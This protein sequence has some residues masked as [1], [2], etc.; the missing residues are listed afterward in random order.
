MS[1]TS[2]Y[3]E[4]I[5]STPLPATTSPFDPGYD[6][7]TLASHLQQSHALISILKLSMACWLIADETATRA[8]IESA[9]ANGVR[10]TTGGGPFEIAVA[11]GKLPEYLDVCAALGVDRVE[12]GEGFTELALTPREVIAMASEHGLEVQF[13]LGKK[14]E[15]AFAEGVVKGLVE[16]GGRWLD[17]GAVELIIEA[18]ESAQAVGLFD[19]D[20]RLNARFAERFVNAFGLDLVTFEAPNKMSQF[21]LID[22]FGPTVRLANVRLEELL[23]VE[24]YRRGLHSDAF[25]HPKLRPRRPPA[26]TPVVTT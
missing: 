11:Q 4:S 21:A 19:L 3:L 7:V 18:R 9:A 13:E 25:E 12:C 2:A 6:P 17:A 8:K 1:I 14:H 10:T 5:G 22:H 24:I 20:G 23:R 15:G 16:Q 26:P